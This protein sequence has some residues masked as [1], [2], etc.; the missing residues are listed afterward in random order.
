MKELDH[1]A[2]WDLESKSN[3]ATQEEAAR[4][5]AN[6]MKNDA[7]TWRGEVHFITQ[8]GDEAGA[9][10]GTSG[11]EGRKDTGQPPK[12]RWRWQR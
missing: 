4:R 5:C 11:R 1:A 12:K 10:V 8:A 7:K 6:E 3:R 2:G 9:L